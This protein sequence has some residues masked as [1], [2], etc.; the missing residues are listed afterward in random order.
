[1]L[2]GEPTYRLKNKAL[3]RKILLADWLVGGLTAVI[4]LLFGPEVVSLLGL[5]AALIRITSIVTLLYA[6]VAFGLASRQPTS[7]RWIRG[8]VTANWFWTLVRVVLFISHYEAATKLGVL[9]LV[10]QIFV[11]GLLAYQ[12]G[13]QVVKAA[14]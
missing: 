6:V 10:L 1:M 9:F 3:L 13:R 2:T 11:V 5:T 4:G 14:A 8:L 12:E 7:I